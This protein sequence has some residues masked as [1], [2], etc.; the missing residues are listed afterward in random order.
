MTTA[1]PAATQADFTLPYYPAA[2]L[3][4]IT[5][6]NRSNLMIASLVYE[7]LFSI[8]ETFA[9]QPCLGQSCSTRDGFTHVVSMRA[10]ATFSDGTPVT[11]QDAAVSLELARASQTYGSR[12]SLITAVKANGSEV[13]ITTSVPHGSLAL[14]LDIPVVQRSSSDSP[15][16]SGPYKLSDDGGALSLV[17]NP[18]WSGSHTRPFPQVLLYP[19]N[20]TDMLVSGFDSR[21][22]SLVATD[23]TGPNALGFSG[24]YEIWDY[25]TSVLLYVGFNTVSGPCRNGDLRLALSRGLDRGSIVSG[26]LS[27]HAQATSLPVSPASALYDSGL[28]A[29]NAYAPALEDKLLESAGFTRSEDG[30]LLQGRRQVS[31]T[32][33]VNSDNTYKL[34]IARYLATQLT[35]DGIRVTLRELPWDSYVAALNKR[36][37]DLYLGEV[38]LPSDF[39]LSSLLSGQGSLNYGGWSDATTSTLLSDF[40]AAS[41]L[42]RPAKAAELYRHIAQQAPIVPLAFKDYSVLTHWGTFSTPVVTQ[43]N[44]FY[45]L[46]DWCISNS[47]SE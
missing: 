14:L 38:K 42:T 40:R 27:R 3:H 10:G 24:D 28:A 31:L 25:P 44:L 12:L 13:T 16:G 26:L 1:E 43:G 2:S 5:S 33:L 22:L 29:E 35:E 15:L 30:S 8:D 23:L 47:S 41:T 46:S 21:A 11:A 7:P 19:V 37:F 36:D 9:A 45:H 6:A 18:H 34:S 32:L 4:P 39:D 17:P 20:E